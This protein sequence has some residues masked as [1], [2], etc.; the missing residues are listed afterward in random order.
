MASTVRDVGVCS[1]P[2]KDHWKLMVSLGASLKKDVD[3]WGGWVME[4]MPAG[5]D[6]GIGDVEV[7]DDPDV[8]WELDCELDCE[9]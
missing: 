9:F 2:E 6:A 5:A 4:I 3:I 1:T 8:D 7:D